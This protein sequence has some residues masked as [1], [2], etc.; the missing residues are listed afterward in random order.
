[1]KMAIWSFQ[2]KVGSRTQKTGGST[3]KEQ[4]DYKTVGLH[5]RGAYASQAT[6]EWLFRQKRGTTSK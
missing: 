5:C 3:E 1:M 6:W 2:G 4:L